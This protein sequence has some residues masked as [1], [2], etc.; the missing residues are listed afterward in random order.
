MNEYFAKFA[1]ETEKCLESPVELFHVETNE[2]TVFMLHTDQAEIS[3]LLDN[4]S[5]WK[6]EGYA[7]ICNQTLNLA[8]PVIAQPLT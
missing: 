6:V 5:K 7:F 4:C 2:K 8:A 1:D 3:K